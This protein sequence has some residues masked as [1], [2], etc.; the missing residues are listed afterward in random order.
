MILPIV[1]GHCTSLYIEFEVRAFWVMPK[2]MPE[3]ALQ[4][5]S[6]LLQRKG[7]AWQSVP[8]LTYWQSFQPTLYHDFEVEAFW[9]MPKQCHSMLCKGRA[10]RAY[11]YLQAMFQPKPFHNTCYIITYLGIALEVHSYKMTSHLL[12]VCPFFISRYFSTFILPSII[13][14]I[15]AGS[16]VFSLSL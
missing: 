10:K 7:E 5:K 4:R 1:F 3:H 12:I 11:P 8:T 6:M 2:A 15:V 9:V 14:F 13:L 16:C